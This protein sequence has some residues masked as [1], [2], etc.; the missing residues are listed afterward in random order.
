MLSAESIKAP[1]FLADFEGR[2][3]KFPTVAVHP[4]T[5]A[6]SICVP[7]ITNSVFESFATKFLVLEIVN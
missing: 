7:K 5:V 6:R 1:M 2:I 4:E 3:S